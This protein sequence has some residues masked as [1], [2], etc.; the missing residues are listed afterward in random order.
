MK[1]IRNFHRHSE[2]YAI[3]LEILGGDGAPVVRSNQTNSIILTKKSKIN[4]ISGL[5]SQI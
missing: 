2:N 1:G 5:N 3:Y 4:C